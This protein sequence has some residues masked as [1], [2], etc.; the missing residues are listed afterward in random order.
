MKVRESLLLVEEPQEDSV[1]NTGVIN[2][3]N[4]PNNQVNSQANP[5]GHIEYVDRHHFHYDYNIVQGQDENALEYSYKV[6]EPNTTSTSTFADQQQNSRELGF[7][8][9][10]AD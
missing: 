1:I 8:R 2:S 5:T 7:T 10:A 4:I 3:P 6:S 9:I